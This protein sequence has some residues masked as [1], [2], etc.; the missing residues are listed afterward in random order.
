MGSNAKVPHPDDPL[1]RVGTGIRTLAFAAGVLAFGGLVWAAVALYE[2]TPSALSSP[3]FMATIA[4]ILALILLGLCLVWYEQRVRDH[5]NALERSTRDAANRGLSHG[6]N[7]GER[8][9]AALTAG[10]TDV[11]L[12]LDEHLNISY[13][14]ASSQKVLGRSPVSMRQ[15]P[16]RAILQGDS[17]LRCEQALPAMAEGTQLQLELTVLHA[18]GHPIPVEATIT[19]H[20]HEQVISGYVVNLRDL[21]DISHFTAELA[22]QALHDPL[23][24]LPNRRMFA[25]LVAQT[26]REEDLH[27]QVVVLDIDDFTEVNSSF[28]H[29]AG[30][31][32]LLATSARLKAAVGNHGA[33][34]RLGGDDFGILLPV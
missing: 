28:G 22:H 7:T 10:S 19:C 30:D 3:A 21:S 33:V 15:L 23:T 5:K 24:D 26:A 13:A 18:D 17:G 14:S 34:A 31:Q 1:R 9:L 27:A 12:V 2:A 16:M 11:A 8:R 25:G 6:L 20:L 32:V 29:S 4:A